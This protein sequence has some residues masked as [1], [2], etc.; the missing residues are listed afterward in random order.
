M[1]YYKEDETQRLLEN[2][3]RWCGDRPGVQS[4]ASILDRL[5]RELRRDS[6]LPI[7]VLAAD[8][9]HTERALKA[10]GQAERLALQR[11]HLTNLSFA[12]QCRKVNISQRSLTTRLHRAHAEFWSAFDAIRIRDSSKMYKTKLQQHV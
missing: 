2:Q 10:M 5:R 7:P 3:A 1:S 6:G 12:E 9:W 4:S 8:A 11:Y